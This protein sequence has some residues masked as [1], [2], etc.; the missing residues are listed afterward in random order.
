MAE[1]WG[2][3]SGRITGS[4]P[5]LR[6]FSLLELIASKDN[7]V[8]LQ[9]LARET[10][11]PKP[12]LHRMLTNFVAEGLLVRQTDKRLYG[13]GPR[14]RAFAETLLM[15]ATQN[16]A[17]HTV[18]RALVQELGETCNITTLS[19]GEVLYLDR[20]ET[21]E[22]LRF[23]LGPGSRVPIHCS[24]SGKLLASQLP[25]STRQVL[26]GHAELERFTD[27]TITDLDALEAEITESRARGYAVDAEE[28]I[29]GLVCF[30]VLVPG[31]RGR[32]SQCIA[33]QGPS[34]R[35]SL[36]DAD[37]VL[38]ALRRAAQAL[39]DIEAESR[40]A[41]YGKKASA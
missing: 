29:Q 8:S 21:S 14:L 19:G 18:L 1:S 31:S 2:D 41:S 39:S 6:M 7:F 9:M 23:H 40:E 38:P 10:G 4:S 20:V 16:G 25:E 11:L 26:L 34:V 5:V 22:P 15:N 13:T 17:R 37:R 32:S 36:A 3:G 27:Q 35:L 12:T 28:F 33:V 30:A 24:A